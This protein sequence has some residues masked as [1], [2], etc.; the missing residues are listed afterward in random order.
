MRRLLRLAE[1]IAVT[2][3]DSGALG[4][5]VTLC[6]VAELACARASVHRTVP[7]QRVGGRSRRSRAGLLVLHRSNRWSGRGRRARRP[8]RPLVV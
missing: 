6:R 2:R 3:Q 5:A 4:V 7:T 8:G 1:R